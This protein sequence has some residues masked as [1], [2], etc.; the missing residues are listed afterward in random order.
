MWGFGMPL[1]LSW[2]VACK[3]HPV[4]LAKLV[5]KIPN[6]QTCLRCHLL[7]SLDGFAS[8]LGRLPP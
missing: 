4:E 6:M 2:V 3:F 8:S 1:M 7:V 5:L